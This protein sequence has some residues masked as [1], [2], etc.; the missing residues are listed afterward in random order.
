MSTIVIKA[1]NNM[2]FFF[3]KGSQQ[4]TFLRGEYF[5]HMQPTLY[6][7]NYTQVISQLSCSGLILLVGMSSLHRL[8]FQWECNVD[9]I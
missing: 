1:N 5:S 2:F 3:A 7:C 9:Y 6:S 4:V 8:V